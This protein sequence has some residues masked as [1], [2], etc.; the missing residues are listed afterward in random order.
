MIKAIIF[1]LDNCIAP[2]DEAGEDLLA[3][4]LEAIRR[5]NKGH[6]PAERLE[7]ALAACWRH[8]LDWVAREYGFSD[9]MFAAGWAACCCMEVKTAM[10][11]YDDLGTLA[12]LPVRRMLVT[13]GFRRLQESKIRALGVAPWFDSIEVDAIDEAD[14]I[15]KEGHFRAILRQHGLAPREVLVVG[16]SA[17]SEIAAGNRL[18]IPTVQI[19]RPGVPPAATASHAI[20]S[21]AEL[22]AIL[23]HY[24]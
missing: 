19:L 5:T 1:D 2:A 20:H 9:E 11:G 16:D 23:E 22:P 14:R 12:T 7:Q 13:T 17:D 24:R 8:P 15:G 21:L 18:G 10:R 3:P 4:T 6:L